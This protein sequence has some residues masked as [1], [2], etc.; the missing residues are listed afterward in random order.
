MKNA[1]TS[2]LFASAAVLVLMIAP[3]AAAQYL[4]EGPSHV[5]YQNDAPPEGCGA[6]DPNAPCY[7]VPSTG[8]CVAATSYAT[9]VSR[10]DCNYKKNDK[11]CN[12]GIACKQLAL[13]EQRACKTNC[14]VDWA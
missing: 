6:I 8:I 7:M 12:G 2:A 10:C 1:V 9:C 3:S 5:P 4:P 11:K 13:A 14:I